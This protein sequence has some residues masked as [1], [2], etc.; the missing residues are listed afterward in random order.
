M[1]ENELPSRPF[2]TLEVAR[3][4]VDAA[5]AE[6]ER[7]ELDH[8]VVT[9][10]DQAGFLIAFARQDDAEPAAIEMC[11][12]KARTAAI[13][14][15]ATKEWKQRLLDGNTWVLG[16]P[17]MHPIEGG[18]NIVVAGRTVGAVGIG[19]GSG[20]IDTE[21]GTAAIAAVTGAP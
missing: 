21:I 4:I 18:Q 15:R 17:E 20:V 16:M 11:L 5:L 1:L 9:V 10:C 7:R 8:L 3:R 12:A 13:F 6:A 19:G 2:L 14:T